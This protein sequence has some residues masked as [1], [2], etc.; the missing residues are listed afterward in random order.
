MRWISFF[1]L[2][3]LLASCQKENGVD[4][5]SVGQAKR[6][7][8]GT[9]QWEYSVNPWTGQA[10][11]PATEGYTLERAFDASG[12][13]RTYRDGQLL[14]SGSWSI[15]MRHVDPINQLGEQHLYLIIDGKADL[16]EISAS[17][18]RINQTPY[19]GPDTYYVKKN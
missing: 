10:F 8:I 17:R 2:L 18:L 15:E 6:W 5:S 1:L 9:W 11:N 12:E 13:V 3:F 4:Q 16:M 14:S 19:D 7:I